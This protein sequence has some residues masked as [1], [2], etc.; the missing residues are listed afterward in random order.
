MCEDY[1]LPTV[2]STLT[3]TI[4]LQLFSTTVTTQSILV[5]S[6]T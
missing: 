6:T 3:S 5:A 4:L 2:Q 1:R